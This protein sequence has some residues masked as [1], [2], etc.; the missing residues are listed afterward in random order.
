M[1][2]FITVN[3]GD[4]FVQKYIPL[5]VINADIINISPGDPGSYTLPQFIGENGSV[6][7]VNDGSV[8]W[9]NGYGA[10]STGATGPTG[11][12]GTTGPT[13]PTGLPGT[14]TGTGATGPTGIDG[15]VGSTGPTGINGSIGSTGP[16]G[17][18]G[19]VG[20]TGINPM[21][22]VLRVDSING[23]DSTASI[24]GA[25]YLTV[26]AAVTAI[27]AGSGYTIWIMPGIYNLSSGGITIPAGCSIRGMSTQTTTLQM[28][29]VVGDTTLVTMGENTRIEDLTLL[30][31]SS[32][33]YNLTGILFGGTTTTST[34]KIR[35]CVVTVNNSGAPVAGGAGTIVAGV[36]ANATGT[37]ST[38]SSFSYNSLK[39]ATFNVYSNG[40]GKKRGVLVTGGSLTTTNVITSRD[41]N[42][43]VTSPSDTT[44][45]GSYVG[46]E[47]DSDKCQ[48]QCRSTTISGPVTAG[49]FTGNDIT[50]TRGSIELG[51]G[52]DIVNKTAGGSAFTTYV[53]PSVIYYGVKGTLSISG[54][55]S[56]YLWPG[57]LNCQ[58]S[59]GQIQPYPDA[60]IAYYRVQQKSVLIGMMSNLGTGPGPTGYYL[61]TNV[62]VNG[63]GIT[64]YSLSYTGTNAGSLS[65]YGSTQTLQ[66]G[67][68]ISVSYNYTGASNNT[69]HDY[70]LQLDLY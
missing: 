5:D 33:H 62:L 6:L 60:N 47:T 21:G 42:V 9:L 63:T 67:D 28:I 29:N 57:S 12:N 48:F 53:Y 32:G 1:G 45:N 2:K 35:T 41:L 3:V 56:G 23:N 27:G 34:S 11:E 58:Q 64:G 54:I 37:S 10:G 59:S 15:A 7:G 26:N 69:A 8:S 40:S 4:K 31:T 46:V 25:P 36:L 52:T 66:L 43:Y 13:G 39:G 38:L 44:S 16:T 20:P 24:G 18:N 55:P 51:P 22:N 17:A 50:Q 65:Y 14:A 70:T 68:L 30:L 61:N 19:S 49:S